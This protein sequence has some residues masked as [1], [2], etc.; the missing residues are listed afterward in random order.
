[1]WGEINCIILRE[2]LDL[3]NHTLE[4]QERGLN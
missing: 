3:L 1:M 2:E 4:M